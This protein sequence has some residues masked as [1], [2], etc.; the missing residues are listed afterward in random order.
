MS[1]LRNYIIRGFDN[2][3]KILHSKYILFLSENGLSKDL[4]ACI[5]KSASASLKIQKDFVQTTTITQSE[6]KLD[7]IKLRALTSFNFLQ[8]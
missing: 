4:F 8:K 6:I 1:L 2:M 7:H 5:V 3:I